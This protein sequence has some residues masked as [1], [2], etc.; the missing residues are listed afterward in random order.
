VRYSAEQ[1]LSR[2]HFRTG[3]IEG[4]PTY[5]LLEIGA[6]LLGSFAKA[7]FDQEVAEAEIGLKIGSWLAGRLGVDG[8]CASRKAIPVYELSRTFGLII[9]GGSKVD[10]ALSLPNL[11]TT[12]TPGST[13]RPM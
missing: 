5:L 7:D 3:Y 10:D 6:D 13:F 12:L 2:Q 1:V 11:F 8:A 4:F 9:H